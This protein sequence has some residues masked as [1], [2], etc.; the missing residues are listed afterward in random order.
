MNKINDNIRTLREKLG[1]SQE[2]MAERLGAKQAAYSYWENGSRKLSYNNLLEIASVLQLSVIDV[3]TYPDK[4]VKQDA[5]DSDVDALVQIRLNGEKKEQVLKL[6]FGNH[7][8][9]IISK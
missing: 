6:L 4:Y 8:L 3:I 2:Y 9:E 1:Y 7:D 5:S